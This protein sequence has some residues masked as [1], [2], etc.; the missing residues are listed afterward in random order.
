MDFRIADAFTDSLARLYGQEQRAAKITAICLQ[1]CSNDGHD[2][3]PL[4]SH[5][6]R[7]AAVR[8]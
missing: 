6:P 5:I 4:Q 1:I 8:E 7:G 3:I 2:D